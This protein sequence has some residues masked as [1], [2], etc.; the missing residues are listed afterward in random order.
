MTSIPSSAIVVATITLKLPPLNKLIVSVCLLF[1]VPV[2]QEN[3]ALVK[4]KRK[5]SVERI[6]QWHKQATLVERKIE[7]P[8][9]IFK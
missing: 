8:I 7:L 4:Q 6:A 2:L 3:N 9:S 1:E 5:N